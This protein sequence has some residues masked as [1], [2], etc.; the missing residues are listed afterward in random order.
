[1]LEVSKILFLIPVACAASEH[2]NVLYFAFATASNREKAKIRLGYNLTVYGNIIAQAIND[3]TGRL[4]Q[5][6]RH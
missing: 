5:L 1:M 3:Y 6:L 4:A 2:V